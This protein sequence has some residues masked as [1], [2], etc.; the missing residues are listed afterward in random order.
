M[1]PLDHQTILDP[2]I[3][4]VVRHGPR[5]NV[6]DDVIA[7]A[8]HLNDTIPDLPITIRHWAICH[9]A[10]WETRV[11]AETFAA[12]VPKLGA[13]EE[14]NCENLRLD[15][16][17]FLPHRM[18]KRAVEERMWR[19]IDCLFAP[20]EKGCPNCFQRSRTLDL[21][22]LVGHQPAI[23]YFLDGRVDRET[24]VA[25][26]E[27]AALIR[28]RGARGRWHLWWVITPQGRDA[29]PEL[30]QKIQS[31]MVVLAVL[32][33]FSTAVLADTAIELAGD[34]AASAVSG[35]SGAISVDRLFMLVAMLLFF[36]SAVVQTGTLLAYDR[37]MMPDRFWRTSRPRTLLGLE[38]L[39]TGV[40]W[41]PPSSTGWIVYQE[42]VRLWRCATIAFIAD[43]AGAIFLLAAVPSNSLECL[44]VAVTAMI[45]VLLAVVCRL[46]LWPATGSPD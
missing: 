13:P 22:V 41:R 1:S 15:P 10:T 44:I 29:L 31:K 45:V 24:A 4:L 40:V 32:A 9:A 14:I 8:Q 34:P 16:D 19:E 33:G 42:S 20:R 21:L 23:D 46:R 35:D 12:H 7:V 25:P 43:G 18:P 36:A 26:A 30:R 17:R 38:N 2:E 28:N 37:L 27:A 11:T 3:L 5:G 39:L 6:R